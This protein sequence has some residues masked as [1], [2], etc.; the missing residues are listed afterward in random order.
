MPSPSPSTS[1][2]PLCP[3]ACCPYP[4]SPLPWTSTVG[5]SIASSQPATC[6]S[7]TSAPGQAAPVCGSQRPAWT[8]SSAVAPLS[9]RRHAADPDHGSPV[10]EQGVEPVPP[11]V[12]VRQLASNRT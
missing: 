8:S 3:H 11:Q 4:P 6:L 12:E 5:P 9:C 2:P 7:S 10:V 1:R